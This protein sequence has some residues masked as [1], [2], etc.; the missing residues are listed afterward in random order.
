MTTALSDRTADEHGKERRMPLLRLMK[1]TR[2][3]WSLWKHATPLAANAAVSVGCYVVGWRLSTTADTLALVHAGAF[4]TMTSIVATLYDYQS[5]LRAAEAAAITFFGTVATQFTLTGEPFLE[6]MRAKVGANTLR[7][8]R[9]IRVSQAF[10]LAVATLVW[11]FADIAP[12]WAPGLFRPAVAG[13][14]ANHCAVA[15]RVTPDES[16]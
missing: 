5:A 8:D 6:R 16:S 3:K 10:L 1:W 7:A 12:K 13:P 14:V 4:A 15:A 9:T 2:T 11:G